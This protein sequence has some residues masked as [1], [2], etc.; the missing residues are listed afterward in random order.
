MFM[1]NPPYSLWSIWS[2][3][4][5]MNHVFVLIL[6][7]VS[8]YCLSSAVIVLVRL[9][10]IGKSTTNEDSISIQRTVTALHKRSA[11]VSRAIQATSYLFG[12]VLFLA[13]Q[14]A[15]M[16]LGLSARPPWT[17]ILWNFELLFT[18]AAHV[19]LVLLVLHVVS[20]FVHKQLNS[21]WSHSKACW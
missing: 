12:V 17:E 4:S 13:L 9:R 16:T 7:G 21:N 6:I 18:L 19:F 8:I 14:Q 10:S 2:S 20:W 3:L 11:N 5:L 1:S 15:P